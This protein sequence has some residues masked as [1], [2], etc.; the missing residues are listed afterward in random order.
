MDIE[1]KL[2]DILSNYLFSTLKRYRTFEGV[3]SKY[4]LYGDVNVSINNYITSNILNRYKFDKVYLYM[5][6]RD[7]NEEG[8]IKYKNNWNFK[9]KKRKLYLL[10]IIEY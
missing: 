10:N 7:I 6:E 5:Q 3:K 2:K 1:Y 9:S 8:Q 4:T